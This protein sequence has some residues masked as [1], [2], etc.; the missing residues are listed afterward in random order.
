MRGSEFPKGSSVHSDGTYGPMTVTEFLIARALRE[1]PDI[2][3]ETTEEEGKIITRITESFEIDI[4]DWFTADD[5]SYLKDEVEKAQNE[6][7]EA[8][9]SILRNWM[10]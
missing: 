9:K 1:W 5:I 10:L 4:P 7:K 3:V 6:F 2:R 8:Q